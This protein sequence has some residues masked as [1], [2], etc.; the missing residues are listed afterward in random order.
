AELTP[1]VPAAEGT[2]RV[3]KP[4][5]KT[6]PWVVRR[7]PSADDLVL[8][9]S[10]RTALV[11][12]RL[13]AVPV[14]SVT[15]AAQQRGTITVG[16]PPHLRLTFKPA[17]DVTRREGTDDAGRDAAFAYYRLPESGSPLEIDVQP[18]RGEV[19]TQV[20][21]QLTLAE[22]GWRWQGRFDVRPVRAEVRAIDLEVP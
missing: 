11:P 2:V 10:L 6:A 21:H 14:F 7:D 12:D 16:G 5:N 13:A 3:A 20:S 15:G 1:E 4:Q 9:I 22:R 18:A 8:D 17:A 19:E